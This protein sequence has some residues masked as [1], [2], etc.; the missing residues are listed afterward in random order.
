MPACAPCRAVPIPQDIRLHDRG[1]GGAG[2]AAGSG[3]G[4]PAGPA[5]PEYA[6]EAEGGFL[7]V[8]DDLGLVEPEAA[9][10]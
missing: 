7:I 8:D 10:G 3:G 4:G 6:R 2:E 1:G 5:R 9:G